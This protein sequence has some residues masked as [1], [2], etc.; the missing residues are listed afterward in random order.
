MHF[1]GVFVEIE[2]AEKLAATFCKRCWY[3]EGGME[4]V[5]IHTYAAVPGWSPGIPGCEIF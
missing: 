1:L 4:V 3:A 5:F 2:I